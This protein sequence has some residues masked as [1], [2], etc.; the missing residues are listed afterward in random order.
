MSLLTPTGTMPA[1]IGT[2]PG[3]ST[4]SGGP[5]Q[6]GAPAKEAWQR[7]M[8]RAQTRD[9]F[10]HDA[11]PTS[12]SGSTAADLS[13][14]SAAPATAPTSKPLPRPPVPW[15]DVSTA[16][17]ETARPAGAAAADRVASSQIG[18]PSARRALPTID[19]EPDLRSVDHETGLRARTPSTREASTADI[20]AN[21]ATRAAGAAGGTDTSA[22]D[23]G[24]LAGYLGA[25]PSPSPSPSP[26]QSQTR[27]PVRVHVQ[28]QGD[29]AQ[30]WI[31]LDARSAPPAAEVA[32]AVVRWLRD[33]GLRAGRITC[34][35]AALAV[36][37]TPHPSTRPAV[38]VVAHLTTREF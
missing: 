27:S 20:A 5:G 33:Q 30:V 31:G 16:V 7:E 35:G 10:R 24:R 19:G 28:W 15:M 37:D 34:N 17:A 25:S 13:R 11:A 29:T 4:P 6:D 21:E 32:G 18:T 22:I 3:A 26:S 23:A 1:P 12:A 9:W 2:P 8:E 36:P 38:D 14:R